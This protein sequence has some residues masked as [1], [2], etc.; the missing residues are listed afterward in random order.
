MV[1][2]S[3]YILI[4]I[5]ILVDSEK[6]LLIIKCINE[7]YAE[8]SDLSLCAE[9]ANL[10]LVPVVNQDDTSC[11]AVQENWVLCKKIIRSNNFIAVK[12]SIEKYYSGKNTI[13]IRASFK[14]DSKI[15]CY[16]SLIEIDIPK[17]WNVEAE[18]L[19]YNNF[20]LDS[21]RVAPEFQTTSVV[22]LIDLCS[23]SSVFVIQDQGD[24]F[25]YYIG[26]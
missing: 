16:E 21:Y 22:N 18:C 3:T 9:N 5:I 11:L 26:N 24:P 15:V 17:P 7:N 23:G 1:S 20:F 2:E 14:V 12:Y 4:I 8:I 19:Y 6:P 13:K 10:K 25:T